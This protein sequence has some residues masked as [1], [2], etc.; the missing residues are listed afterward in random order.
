[1]NT[2]M[3]ENMLKAGFTSQVYPEGFPVGWPVPR[4]MATHGNMLAVSDVDGCRVHLY[5]I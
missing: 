2:V 5:R 1:M 4:D 3:F